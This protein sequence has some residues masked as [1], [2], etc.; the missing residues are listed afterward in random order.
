MTVVCCGVG[1]DTGNVRPV[2]GV[3]AEGRFEYV[4]IP[5]KGATAET[6]TYGSL[7][8]RHG[9]GTFADLLDGIRPG[10]DGEWITDPGAVREQPVHRDP[11]LAALTYGE[12]R[13]GYVAK[14]RELEPGDIVAFYGGFPGP[15]SDYKHRYLFGY[16]TV[17]EPPVVLDPAMDRADVEAVLAEHPD[18]AH[19]KRFAGHGDLYYHDPEFTDRP[20]PVVIVPGEAPGGLLDRAIRLSDRRRGPNYYMSDDVAGALSPASATERGTHLGGFKPAVRCDVTAEA[21]R[22]FV[23]ERS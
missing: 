23:R 7:D 8:R 19:A 11:D 21:F 10:S 4:P 20:R 22:A 9:E 13:P 3:D 6:A 14:L 1:A 12:H 16:F 2:P 17:A 18:N 5:E 15:D